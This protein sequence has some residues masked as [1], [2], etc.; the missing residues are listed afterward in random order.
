VAAV[1]TDGPA[2]QDLKFVRGDTLHFAFRLWDSTYDSATDSWVKSNP[3]DLTGY[4]FL[5]Q[6]RADENKTSALI[7]ALTATVP[8]QTVTANKGFV[9]LS[10]APSV[11]A[12]MGPAAL[13]GAAFTKIA[14]WDCEVTEPASGPTTTIWYG[15]VLMKPDV[16]R[17][18]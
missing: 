5:A 6:I 12:T 9:F 14:V 15:D 13:V 3:L 8:N 1:I 10:V 2:K 7:T 17:A 11:T 4:T 18:S 16:A